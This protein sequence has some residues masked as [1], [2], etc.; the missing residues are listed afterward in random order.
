MQA[1]SHFKSETSGSV[2]GIMDM[3][4][5]RL[6]TADSI[7]AATVST[8]FTRVTEGTT[9]GI[10]DT[11]SLLALTAIGQITLVMDFMSHPDATTCAAE[12]TG[13]TNA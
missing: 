6:A 4:I 5:D 11:A 12:D 9:L 8:Q 7:R 3:A 1:G 10:T 2:R 13:T